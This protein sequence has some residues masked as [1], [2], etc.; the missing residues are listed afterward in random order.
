MRGIIVALVTSM[1][2]S[3]ERFTLYK[4][5]AV[6]V[7]IAIAML[8]SS[9]AREKRFNIDAELL[10]YV[11]SFESLTRVPINFDM[12]IVD[13]IVSPTYT[14]IP[15]TIGLCSVGGPSTLVQISRS[16]WD[17]A[18][19]LLRE[20]AVYHELGHCALGYLKHDDTVDSNSWS[21]SIMSTYIQPLFLYEQKREK[22]VVEL[23]LMATGLKQ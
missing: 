22:Y 3:S 6:F 10:P 5:L 16:W 11:Q 14:V 20:Q 9:C 12:R 13:T 4:L 1:S 19:E 18:S 23:L 21:D 2:T 15:S 17:G 8:L 7:L